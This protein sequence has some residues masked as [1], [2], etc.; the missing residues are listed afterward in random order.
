VDRGVHCKENVL[1]ISLMKYVKGPG[2][3]LTSKDRILASK[4]AL[5]L[6]CLSN[7]KTTSSR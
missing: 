1:A 2:G 3:F 6:F 4:K 7:V 5:F